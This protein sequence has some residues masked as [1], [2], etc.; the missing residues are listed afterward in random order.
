MCDDMSTLYERLITART[1][2]FD[3]GLKLTV[4][5]EALKEIKLQHNDC[6]TCLR[7]MLTT[8][9]EAVGPL[10]WREVCA[11]LRSPTVDRNDVAEMI[12]RKGIQLD[13]RNM[14]Y[15]HFHIQQH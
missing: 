10:S 13:S 9:L 15:L 2:W 8:R 11:C 14:H 4:S 12:E 5:V 6:K 1:E 3:I 7:E